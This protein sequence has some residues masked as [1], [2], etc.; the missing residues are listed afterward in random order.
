MSKE[1]LLTWELL[2]KR[3]TYQ[4]LKDI[5]NKKILDYGSGNGVM[6]S[7]LSKHNDVIAIEPNKNMVQERTSSNTFVQII[8]GI[9]ELKK[10][11]LESFD[12]IV[13]HNV[14]EYAECREEIVK[15]F[16]RL[17]KPKGLLSIVKHNKMGRVMQMVVLLNQ[18]EM[19]HQLLDGQ[20]GYAQDFGEIHYYEDSDI[21]RWENGFVLKK[22]WGMRTFWDLQQNQVIQTDQHWQD[23]MIEIE[24]RVSFIPEFQAISFFHHILFEKNI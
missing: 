20:N 7:L 8:G 17:L 5:H 4:Q 15:E 2:Q 16:Y 3:M 22:C 18:F 9:E 23:Q 24:E 12:V 21:C 6:A 1:K 10:L 14:L 11:P 13:C 19:A